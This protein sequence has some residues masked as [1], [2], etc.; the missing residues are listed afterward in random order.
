MRNDCTCLLIDNDPD[1]CD[2]FLMALQ[3]ADPDLSCETSNSGIEALSRLNTH[4][5]FIPSAIFIDMNMPLMNGKQCLQE[6]RKMA[7]LKEVPMYVYSTSADPRAVAEVKTLG[8]R[9]FL[10]KPSGFIPLVE[11]L[12]HLLSCQKTLQ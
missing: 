11:L 9:D 6:L 4:P 8:A 1:D 2:I 5:S 10:V 3:E 7:R 12:S